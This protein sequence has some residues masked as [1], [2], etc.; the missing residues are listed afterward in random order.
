MRCPWLLCGALLFVLAP[1]LPA[2]APQ[3]GGTEEKKVFQIPFKLTN[4]QHIMVRIKINGKGP[5][6][7][8]MDT[9]A[10]LLHVAIPVGEKAGLKADKKGVAVIDKLEIEGGPVL[11]NFKCA[12]ETPFQLEG[13]NAM[14]LA[15]TELHGMLG[16]TVLSHYR[17]DIDLRKDKMTW[18]KL[19]YQPPLPVPLGIDKKNKT[20]KELDSI[21]SLM[22]G[23][24]KFMGIKPPLPPTPRGFLGIEL[25]EKDGGVA[26]KAVLAKGPADGSGLKAGHVIQAINGEKVATLQEAMTQMAK[27][28]PGQQVRL[29]VVGGGKNKT[30]ITL[31]AGEG[32]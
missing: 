20:V 17:L 25:A 29:A 30:I 9:G 1:P 24:A 19:D 11:T 28:L 8:I 12:V 23:Y 6:N 32:L 27:V 3:A 14:G 13:M 4:S 22:K 31:T 18:T 26:V 21:A 16:Y 15:G 10:P 2:A 5:Y 7:F